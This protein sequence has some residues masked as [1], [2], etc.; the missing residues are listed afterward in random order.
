M[1]GFFGRKELGMKDN[2]GKAVLIENQKT[3][4]SAKAI[5]RDPKREMKKALNCQNRVIPEN[6]K[7][8]ESITDWL[9]N[10]NFKRCGS[11]K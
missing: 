3:V 6:G 4:I 8:E 11:M 1:Q 9:G 2:H 5:I 7:H 10:R